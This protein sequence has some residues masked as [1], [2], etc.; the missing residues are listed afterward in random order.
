MSDLNCTR[1]SVDINREYFESNPS[2]IDST[3]IGIEKNIVECANCKYQS[4]TYKPYSVMSL[5]LRDTL[6]KSITEYF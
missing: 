1:S 4:V 2:I 6:E 5:E 3:F